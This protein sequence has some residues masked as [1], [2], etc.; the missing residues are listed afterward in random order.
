MATK[1]KIEI[2]YEELNEMR[3]AQAKLQALENG[4]VDNWEGYDFA[5][6]ELRKVEAFDEEVEALV[7]EIMAELGSN[8]YEPSKRGGGIAFYDGAAMECE[9]LVRKFA[10]KIKKL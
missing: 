1:G 7:Q 10:E 5:L 2:T 9:N 3:K 8:S 4:G 6:E